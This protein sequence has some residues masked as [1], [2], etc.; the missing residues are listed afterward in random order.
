MC[1]GIRLLVAGGERLGGDGGGAAAAAAVLVGGGLFAEDARPGEGGASRAL[2][3]G[4]CAVLTKA[5]LVTKADFLSPS[6]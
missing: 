1:S 3:V 2:V 5:R 6:R 4:G